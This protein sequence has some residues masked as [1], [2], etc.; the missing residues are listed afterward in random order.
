MLEL[1]FNDHLDTSKCKES[2]EDKKFVSMLS[3]GIT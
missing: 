1:D 3:E 2:R